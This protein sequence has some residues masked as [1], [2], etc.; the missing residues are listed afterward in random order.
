MEVD[1]ICDRVSNLNI[2]DTIMDDHIFWRSVF[3]H[4]FNEDPNIAINMIKI[5]DGVNSRWMVKFNSKYEERFIHAL[6]NYN[7]TL[8]NTYRIGYRKEMTNILDFYNV[9]YTMI[10]VKK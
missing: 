1:A 3:I 10:A 9:V 2:N 5:K 7:N 8:F 6:V 4:L